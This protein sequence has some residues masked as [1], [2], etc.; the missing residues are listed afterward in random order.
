[1]SYTEVEYGGPYTHELD[2]I[3][4]ERVLAARMEREPNF[5]KIF[6]GQKISSGAKKIIED[7]VTNAANADRYVTPTA[8]DPDLAPEIPLA[9]VVE[10]TP[11]E[12]ALEEIL[13]TPSE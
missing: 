11:A 5:D 2:A 3:R 10:E 1:M 13:E 6:D 12:A 7:I 9:P 4:D 8:F